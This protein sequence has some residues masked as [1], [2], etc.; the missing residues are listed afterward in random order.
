MIWGGDTNWCPSHN[1]RSRTAR[2]GAQHDFF[3]YSWPLTLLLDPQGYG[4]F[5]S[6]LGVRGTIL[7][8]FLPRE[9]GGKQKCQETRQARQNGR[10]QGCRAECS[11][12]K[13]TCLVSVKAC[14]DRDAVRQG[15]K[16]LSPNIFGGKSH[17]NVNSAFQCS[18]TRAHSVLKK[19]A[20][21]FILVRTSFAPGTRC[22]SSSSINISGNSSS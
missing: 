8:L 14:Q 15:V 10:C 3:T 16:I 11:T 9:R 5:G 4:C 18:N 17:D 2:H 22:Y 7:P 6:Y 13:P 12:L 21:Y 19:I 1:A 20:M